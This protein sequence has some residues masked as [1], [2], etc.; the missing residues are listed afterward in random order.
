MADDTGRSNPWN[1]TAGHAS[2]TLSRSRSP[3]TQS[4]FSSPQSN[5]RP[6]SRKRSSNIELIPFPTTP[7][8]ST[9]AY[10]DPDHR[11]VQPAG[12][13]GRSCYFHSDSTKMTGKASLRHPFCARF[14]GKLNS[15]SV[16]DLYRSLGSD[17]LHPATVPDQSYQQGIQ[18]DEYTLAFNFQGEDEAIGEISVSTNPPSSDRSVYPRRSDGKEAKKEEHRLGEAGRRREESIR[19]DKIAKLL[20]DIFLVN[21]KPKNKKRGSAHYTKNGVLD[22]VIMFIESLPSELFT[23]IEKLPDDARLEAEDHIRRKAQGI[24]NKDLGYWISNE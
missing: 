16:K 5:I 23:S 11:P 24:R 13:R 14:T 17:Q 21:A 12:L 10:T 4:T 22:G 2:P 15:G 7:C 8:K 6:A 20:P 9:F 3:W 1:D 18:L 19:R